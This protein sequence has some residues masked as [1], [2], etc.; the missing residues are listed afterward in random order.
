MTGDVHTARRIVVFLVLAALVLAASA[1]WLPYYAIGPGP[2]REV[3]PLIRIRDRPVYG[4]SGRFVMTSVRINQLTAVG[5]LLAW[6]DPHRAVV[7]RKALYAPGESDAEEQQRAI[8]QMD[9][10]KLDAAYVVLHQLGDYPKEHGR[11]VI[12]ESVVDG[13]AAEGKLFP[14]DLI[15]AIDGRPI[16]GLRAASAAIESAPS[17]STLGFDVTVDGSAEHVDL[18]RRPCGGERRPLVGLRMIP[19]FPF[20]VAISSGDVGGPSAGLMWAIALYD[21]LTPEDLTAGRT[22]AGTGAIGTDGTVY[23]IGGIE[24]KIVAARDAGADALLLPEGN[25]A[26]ARAAG[27]GG[28]QLVPV[29]TF[30]DAIA[31]LHRGS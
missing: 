17:G 22:I 30:D 6:L 31:W 13:C 28:I 8:S 14:G 23:P 18:V 27:I 21:L 24:E 5:S 4:S 9:Q 19:R 1:V 12:V 26:E 15:T 3:A 7:S 29:A 10:S 11:G 20:P 2:A 16:A 25:L